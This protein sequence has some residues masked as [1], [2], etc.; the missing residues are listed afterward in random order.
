MNERKSR[1]IVASCTNVA[2]GLNEHERQCFGTESLIEIIYLGLRTNGTERARTAARKSERR[3]LRTNEN[4]R[5]SNSNKRGKKK[6][7]EK[8][9][10][11]KKKNFQSTEDWQSKLNVGRFKAQILFQLSSTIVVTDNKPE[12]IISPNETVCNAD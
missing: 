9:A 3:I 2:E 5:K 11:N 6:K 1:C 4:K 7:K 12:K 8:K 10:K